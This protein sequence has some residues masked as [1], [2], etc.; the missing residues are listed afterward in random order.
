MSK[1][2]KLVSVVCGGLL[3]GLAIGCGAG[4]EA[5]NDKVEGE[6]SAQGLDAI[7][8]YEL[9]IYM[10]TE[11]I[12]WAAGTLE[13]ATT[14]AG[15]P[16]ASVIIAAGTS[17]APVASAIAAV[18]AAP[19]TMTSISLA[20]TTTT[21]TGGTTCAASTAVVGAGGLTVAAVT[22]AAA[23][24]AVG[25]V[26]AID[27]YT[28]GECIWTTVNNAGGLGVVLGFSPSPA[29]APVPGAVTVGCYEPSGV[30]QRC[31]DSLGRYITNYYSWFGGSY[32]TCRDVWRYWSSSSADARAA[33][34]TVQAQCVTNT[35]RGCCA[36][37]FSSFCPGDAGADGG[38]G[39]ADGGTSDGAP[40][41]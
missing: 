34:T 4:A 22:A 17:E 31:T 35:T 20:G 12:R 3:L 33:C 10:G 8:G 6:R 37:G 39:G 27:C 41:P 26:L 16:P 19:G 1:R 9:V 13:F 15:F 7:A 18:Q 30:S 21:A 36:L 25:T 28:Y 24:V 29:S 40:P 5:T 23:V 14:G 32:W 11:G 38:D 2:N